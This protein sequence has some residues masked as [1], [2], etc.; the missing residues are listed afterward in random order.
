MA[1]DHPSILRWLG[2]YH[3]E[4]RKEP[5][6]S[7]GGGGGGGWR[8]GGVLEFAPGYR[9]LGGPPSLDTITRDV[10]PDSARFGGEAIREIAISISSALAHAHSRGIAHGDLYAHNIL[11]AARSRLT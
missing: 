8:L 11:C 9:A 10:Y 6:E 1:L 4:G 5:R 3:V 7:H 2:Y